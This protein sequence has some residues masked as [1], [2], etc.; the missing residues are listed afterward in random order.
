MRYF[1]TASRRARSATALAGSQ[2][3]RRRGGRRREDASVDAWPGALGA[4]RGA[5]ARLG[6]R[7]M[8]WAMQQLDFDALL[9]A[10]SEPAAPV[11]TR[12]RVA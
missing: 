10:V 2:V 9:E 8:E 7:S 1:V 4:L 12:R 5:G 3:R 11:V 6:R